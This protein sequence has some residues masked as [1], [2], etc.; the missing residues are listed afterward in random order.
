M[1]PRAPAAPKRMPA[2]TF[3]EDGLPIF[4]TDD[5]EI[6]DAILRGRD[7][8][9]FF[10][11]TFLSANFSER[12]SAQRME[13][14]RLLDDRTIPMLDVLAWRG[15]GKSTLFSGFITKE[16][17]YR[18]CKFP[19]Y[20]GSGFD[21]ATQWTEDLKAELMTNDTLRDVFGHFKQQ[22][23]SD[24]G[25]KY[26]FS[27]KGFFLMDPV[28]GEP[29]AFV[30]GKGAGQKVR[31]L[32]RR[33]GGMKCR[34]DFVAVDDLESDEDVGN[35]ETMRKTRQWF[36]S[37]L[38]HVVP[39]KRPYASGVWRDKWRPS[40]ANPFWVP[41]W[42]IAVLDSLK[43]RDALAAQLLEMPGWVGVRMPKASLGEDGEWHTN[44]PELFS[45]S[46]IRREIELEQSAGTFD[47]YCREMLC[48]AS[49]P[50]EREWT[51]ESFQ[52]FDPG[53]G[54]FAD[55]KAG[56]DWFRYIISDPARSL[57]KRSS[58]TAA[59]VVAVN[60]AKGLVAFCDTLFARMT[61]ETIVAELFRLADEWN[62]DTL[63]IEETGLV[64]WIKNWLTNAAAE[65]GKNYR[66]LWLDAGS[67]GQLAAEFG[68]GRHAVKKARAATML[69]LF[70]PSPAHPNGHV[71]FNRKLKGGILQQH[72]LS[73]PDLTYWDLMD[74]GG[75]IGKV[76]AT[77]RLVFHAQVVD[78]GE[79]EAYDMQR[80]RMDEAFKRRAWRVC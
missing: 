66:F 39:K 79:A 71:W 53:S 60:P 33:I 13:V 2:V 15:F 36:H 69:S 32:N 24:D 4:H 78:K 50:Q 22:Q 35:D 29:F 3:R 12:M 68:T 20:V 56:R 73:Y 40:D 61:P 28:T 80:S 48:V 21:L 67:G 7:D 6:R 59:L 62:V 46:A 77:D 26:G 23:V 9:A 38:K 49:D 37:A 63:A 8:S 14:C 17:C 16:V 54:D 1:P 19:L 64:L 31:G 34:P 70:R 76:M 58:Y 11:K 5:T 25:I 30:A 57:G 27:Q 42:R 75:H 51:E 41:P 72:M 44:V 52:F 45:D 65:Q 47:S 43:A 10:F 74:C 55:L 18:V